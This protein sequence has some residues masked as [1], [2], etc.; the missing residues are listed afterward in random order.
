MIAR[1]TGLFTTKWMGETFN[2]TLALFS[3]E[4]ETDSFHFLLTNAR[5]CMLYL[6]EIK[7]V[8]SARAL[9]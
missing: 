4:A 7:D 1:F 8:I 3:E 5:F 2:V 6:R 9:R